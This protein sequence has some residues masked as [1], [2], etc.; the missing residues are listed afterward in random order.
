MRNAGAKDPAVEH[1]RKGDVLGI[2]RS[3]ENLVESVHP[4]DRNDPQRDTYLFPSASSLQISIGFQTLIKFS[5]E[6]TLI[7]CLSSFVYLESK[8]VSSGLP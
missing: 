1:I 5:Y 4:G 2:D 3:P 6:L 7:F 8:R